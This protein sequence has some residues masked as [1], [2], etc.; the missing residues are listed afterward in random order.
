M[1]TAQKGQTWFPRLFR[2]PSPVQIE[3]DGVRP[4]DAVRASDAAASSTRDVHSTG[5]PRAASV[6]RGG[7]VFIHPLACV[8]PRARLG[9][10]VHVGP[11]CMVGPDVTLGDGCQLISHVSILGVTT[12]GRDNVFY[13]NAVIGAPPQDKKFRGESTRLEIGDRNQFR[14]ACT[15]HTGTEK[16]GGVTRIGS[17]NLL[18][19]NAHVGHD[20]SIGSHCVLSNNVMIAGHC[21]IGNHVVLSGGAAMHHFVTVDDFVYAAG[22]CTITHDVP[23]FVKVDG[24]D[25]IRGLNSVGLRRNGFAD[26]DVSALEEAIFELFLNRDRPPLARV[27]ANIESG[28]AGDFSHNPH[29]RRVIAFIQRRNQGKHG[30]YLES[31]RRA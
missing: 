17:D 4:A 29:V 1:S 15:V 6:N 14:E 30:R 5:F 11:F 28:T 10:D 31:L 23:P 13:P 12:V 7:G 18:M 21:Q 20:A 26:E 27:I 22:Y 8:D 3:L 24:S 9:N 19:V 16:G 25:R 2:K